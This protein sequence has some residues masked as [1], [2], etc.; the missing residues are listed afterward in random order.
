MAMDAFVDGYK[1]DAHQWDTIFLQ[2]TKVFA[3]N[4][5]KNIWKYQ[6]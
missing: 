2:F 3:Q 6:W 1:K 5:I 4:K